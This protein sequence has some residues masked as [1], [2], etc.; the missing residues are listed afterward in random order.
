MTRERTP[1]ELDEGSA[2]ALGFVRCPFNQGD[3]RHKGCPIKLYCLRGFIQPLCFLEASKAAQEDSLADKG[4]V[5]RKDRDFRTASGQCCM[6]CP[7]GLAFCAVLPRPQSAAYPWCE[8]E[9]SPNSWKWAFKWGKLK[10]EHELLPNLGRTSFSLGTGCLVGKMR[11]PASQE[12]PS[13]LLGMEHMP[14]KCALYH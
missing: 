5:L 1:E 14:A 12:P 13:P 3:F 6:L 11:A 7:S 10:Q 4:P 8:S 2:T 9:A